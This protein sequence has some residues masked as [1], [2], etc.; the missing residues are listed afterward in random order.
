MPVILYTNERFDVGA[1][2]DTRDYCDLN[3]RALEEATAEEREVEEFLEEVRREHYPAAPD[4][5]CAIVGTLLPSK[6]S[7]VRHE[8]GWGTTEIPA[9]EP[10]G[11]GAYCYHIQAGASADYMLADEAFVGR[12]VQRWPLL[13]DRFD[14][15]RLAQAYW[16]GDVLRGYSMLI[17]GQ[18]K[19]EAACRWPSGGRRL[20]PVVWGAG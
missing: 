11:M 4:R 10:T 14:K 13:R 7:G 8:R 1:V 9:P 15:W 6:Q 3:R 18:V 2:F 12:L 17:R 20:Q 16:N 19:V 5:V